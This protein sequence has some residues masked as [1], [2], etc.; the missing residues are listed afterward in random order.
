MKDAVLEG[1][2]PSEKA[3]GMSLF[4]FIGRNESA[5]TMFNT[6]MTGHSAIITKKLLQRFHGLDG[7][8][9]LIDVGGGT[10]AM[11]QT[12]IGYHKHLRGINYDLPHVI[13]QAPSIKGQ[14]ANFRSSINHHDFQYFSYKV[15]QVGDNIVSYLRAGVEHVGGSM[16]ESIPSGDAVLMKVFLHISSIVQF[17]FL[18]TH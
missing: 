6:A 3:Y 10:G 14:I 9:V 18:V 15:C 7:L 5:N 4:E 2:V 1:A 11:L 17:S 16:F 13:G 12:I 8:S